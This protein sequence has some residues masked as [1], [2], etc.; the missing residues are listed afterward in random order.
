MAMEEWKRIEPLALEE[1]YAATRKLG[2]KISGEHGIGLKRKRS[3]AQFMDPVELGLIKAIQKAWDP[4]GIMNP[5]KI[6]DRD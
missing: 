6:F 1:L 3:M 4:K 5:G 2:G